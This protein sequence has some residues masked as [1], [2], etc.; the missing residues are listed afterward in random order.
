[1]TEWP[2]WLDTESNSHKTAYTFQEVVR[3]Y[4]RQYLHPVK[5]ISGHLFIW[6][7]AATQEATGRRLLVIFYISEIIF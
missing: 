7:S 1:M 5:Y 4:F 2:Y 6:S 3:C